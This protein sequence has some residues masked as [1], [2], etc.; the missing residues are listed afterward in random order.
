MGR[1]GEG[2]GVGGPHCSGRWETSREPT[3]PLWNAILGWGISL[4]ERGMRG[5]GLDLYED[6]GGAGGVADTRVK[7]RIAYV[8]P[9]SLCTREGERIVGHSQSPT[10]L[11]FRAILLPSTTARNTS[12]S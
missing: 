4:D 5:S 6:T 10:F 3:L 9:Q 11:Y 2:A 12:A 8:P 1:T 7:A